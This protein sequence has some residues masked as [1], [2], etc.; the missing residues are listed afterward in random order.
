MRP[1]MLWCCPS[2][3][4]RQSVHPQL[5]MK[6][7]TWNALCDFLVYDLEKKPETLLILGIL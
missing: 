3:S 6:A 1:I 5:L 2:V 4:V 7:I